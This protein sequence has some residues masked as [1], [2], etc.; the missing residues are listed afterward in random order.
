MTAFILLLFLIALASGGVL[1]WFGAGSNGGG[2]NPRA[3]RA[4]DIYEQES[5][6]ATLL[7]PDAAMAEALSQELK[8]DT[9]AE[10]STLAWKTAPRS[11][12]H[13]A[14]LL[15]I[16][17]MLLAGAAYLS[18][19]DYQRA[20]QGM[21]AE[22]ADPFVGLT[23]LQREN[24]RLVQL[25]DTLRADPANSVAWAELGEQYLLLNAFDN[26]YQAY[27]RALAIR[28]ENAELL[29]AQATV[30]YYRDGQ[31][32]NE[33]ARRLIARALALDAQEV[34]ALMLLASDAFFS[35][36]YARAIALW[37]SLLDSENPRVNRASLIEAIQTARMMQ[38]SAGAAPR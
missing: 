37:Q 6:R 13:V 29:A 10:T 15:W 11:S 27:E 30:L 36:D 34:S 23:P 21:A 24:Q 35:A 28:G 8:A 9:Q 20:S 31:Q 7:L 33:P 22:R 12:V 32:L 38:R 25:M 26:A 2:Q 17:S 18:S 4:A 5:R 14:L 1:L 19:G 3:R 16:G